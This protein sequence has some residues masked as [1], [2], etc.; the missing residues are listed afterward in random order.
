MDWIL[1]HL[2]LLIVIAGSIAYYFNQRSRLKQGLPPQDEDGNVLGGPTPGA[3]D[4]AGMEAE[5]A[6]RTQELREE[7]R[8]KRE[9]RERGLQ[10]PQ[11][12]SLPIPAPARTENAPRPVVFDPMA[13]MMRE[14]TRRMTPEVQPQPQP[15]PQRA[16]LV[17]QEA[18]TR[19]RDLAEK[20]RNLEDAERG[21]R[22][23]AE[24]IRSQ[25]ADTRAAAAPVF[26]GLRTPAELRRAI[27]CAEILGKPLS[28]RG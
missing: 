25:E 22:R 24:A 9:Q 11:P 21:V 14:L 28:L 1:D 18:L 16:P 6:R 10:A 20:L 2:Q 12:P 15:Q 5:E 27:L 8:Q 13:E 17:D 4:P 3:F 23:R 19:Q 7:L 26:E